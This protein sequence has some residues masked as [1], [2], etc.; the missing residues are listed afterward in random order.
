MI[1]PEEKTKLDLIC[2]ERKTDI[3]GYSRRENG[4]EE[5]K[6][7]KEVVDDVKRD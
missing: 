2:Y 7:K 3:N 6:R 1:Q 4:R 5:E